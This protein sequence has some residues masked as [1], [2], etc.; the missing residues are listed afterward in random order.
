MSAGLIDEYLLMTFPVTIGTGKRLF[1]DGTVPASLR[2]IQGS[3]SR[4]GIVIAR[5][6]RAGEL[7]TGSFA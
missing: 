4:N 5:Y 1:A 7:A 3:I 6:E 2:L